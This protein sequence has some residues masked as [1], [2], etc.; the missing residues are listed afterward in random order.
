MIAIKLDKGDELVWSNISTGD[1]GIL[2]ITKQGKAIRFGEES[3]RAT[4]RDTIGVIGIK[5]T[6]DDEVIGMDVIAKQ[7]NPDVLTIMENGLGKK[8][9]VRQFPKQNRGGQGVKVAKVTDR[10]GTVV[11]AQVVPLTAGEV[12]MTSLKGQVVKLDINQIPR[13]SRDTQGV[14]LMRFS[15]KNDRVASAACIEKVTQ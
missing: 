2:L 4:G 3:V 14:I 11:V 1:N 9:E 15:D 8:T 7:D 10:T 13:L 6:S 12:I 5:L